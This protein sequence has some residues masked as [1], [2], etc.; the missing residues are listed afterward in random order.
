MPAM[1]RLTWLLAAPILAL[2]AACTSAAEQPEQALPPVV[3]PLDCADPIDA[4][5]ELPE[6]YRSV[7]GVVAFPTGDVLQRGPTTAGDDPESARAFSKF[8]LVVRAGTAFQMDV[9]EQSQPNALIGWG[10]N[11]VAEL[12]PSI[13]VDRCRGECDPSIQPACPE[14][15]DWKWVVYPGGM[16]TLEPACVV[17]TVTADDETA[18]VELPVGVRC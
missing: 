9:G 18:S 8:G 1:A 6:N 3:A 12:V 16:W 13:T 17:L 11:G 5:N 10:T 14:G 7:G 15:D 2:S 4:L